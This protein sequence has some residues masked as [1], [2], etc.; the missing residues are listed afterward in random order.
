M[1]PLL[2]MLACAPDA[3]GTL[4]ISGLDASAEVEEMGVASMVIGLEAIHLAEGVPETEHD[5]QLIHDGDVGAAIDLV[6]GEGEIR[7]TLDAGAYKLV[8]LRISPEFTYLRDGEG[9]AEERNTPGD[10][11]IGTV[12]SIPDVL[13]D[14]FGQA[15]S[16]DTFEVLSEPDMHPSEIH[17]DANDD[18]FWVMAD[19]IDI[20]PG[21]ELTLSLSALPGSLEPAERCDDAPGKPIFVMGPPE[22]L[23]AAR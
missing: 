22:A 15:V 7:R 8:Y 2:T 14:S 4:T 20:A 3:Q 11:S 10:A 21:E 23:A 1:L 16:E 17:P 13:E 19:P 18:Y 9:C 6:T 5:W 12:M